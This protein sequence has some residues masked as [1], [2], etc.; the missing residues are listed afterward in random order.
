MSPLEQWLRVP[1]P[2]RSPPKLNVPAG[3]ETP[4]A[5]AERLIADRPRD[6]SQITTKFAPTAEGAGGANFVSGGQC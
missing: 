6:W 4:C 5:R 3:A 1:R 2:G